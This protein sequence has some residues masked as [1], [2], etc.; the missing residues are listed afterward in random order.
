MAQI[1]T[2]SG[3]TCFEQRTLSCLCS[4]I[5]EPY[6]SDFRDSEHGQF[7]QSFPSQKHPTKP[8]SLSP[9]SRPDPISKIFH[10]KR[11]RPSFIFFYPTPKSYCSVQKLQKL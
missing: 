10:S 4:Q 11:F 3:H 6:L 7:E 1:A 9:H 8:K 5:L 2:S